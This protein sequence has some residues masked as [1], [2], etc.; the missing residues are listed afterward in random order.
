M[1][2]SLPQMKFS[3]TPVIRRT[4]HACGHRVRVA[5]NAGLRCAAMGAETYLP[6][7]M[8]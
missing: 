4:R 3:D 8:A 1:R 6:G 5:R 7:P 2:S